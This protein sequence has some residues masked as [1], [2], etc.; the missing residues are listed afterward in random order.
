MAR[1]TIRRWTCATGALMIVGMT[2]PAAAM[3]TSRR[4]LDFGRSGAALCR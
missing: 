2:Q 1:I 3:L 4:W